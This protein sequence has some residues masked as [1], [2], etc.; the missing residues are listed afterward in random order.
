MAMVE[1]MRAAAEALVQD[2]LA[3]QGGSTLLRPTWTC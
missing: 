3:I 2:R 1:R